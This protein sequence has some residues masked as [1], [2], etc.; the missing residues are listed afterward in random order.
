MLGGGD[1]MNAEVPLWAGYARVKS[2]GLDGPSALETAICKR[3][4]VDRDS[5]RLEWV[6]AASVGKAGCDFRWW[7]RW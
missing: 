5:P 4:C 7:Y 6:G 2:R 3:V 1:E